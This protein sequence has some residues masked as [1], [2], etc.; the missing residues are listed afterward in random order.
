MKYILLY[1][2][3]ACLMLLTSCSASPVVNPGSEL[4][5]AILTE[6]LR[7]KE[8]IKEMQK[9]IDQLKKNQ[10]HVSANYEISRFFTA[11][12]KGDI[13]EM[14]KLVSK[15]A[16]FSSSGIHFSNGSTFRFEEADGK[17]AILKEHSFCEEK[18]E[19][20]YEVSSIKASAGAT[21]YE[22]TVIE[23]QDGWKIENLEEI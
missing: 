19:L 4:E 16:V 10:D 21:Q 12:Q 14:N 8:K 23:S 6:N 5:E 2:I 3:L 7:L 20:I 13:G 11:L 15:S 17:K 18:G 9:E 1:A 22:I